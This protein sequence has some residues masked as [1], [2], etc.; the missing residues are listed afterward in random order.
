MSS[1]VG[2]WRAA[3]EAL[4]SERWED[5]RRFALRMGALLAEQPNTILLVERGAAP[6][7][8]RSGQYGQLLQIEPDRRPAGPP[9][10]RIDGERAEP[11]WLD[12]ASYQATTRGG[13]KVDGFLQGKA[14]FKDVGLISG[15]VLLQLADALS[16]QEQLDRDGD[17]HSEAATALYIIG[18]AL[19]VAGALTNPSAD[20]RAWELMPEAWYLVAAR[21]PAGAHSL[22]IEGR[23]YALSVP[24]RGQA[25]A[26]LPSLEPGGPRQ[27]GIE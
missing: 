4:P 18:G 9:A 12:S 3:C 15:Q 11:L 26:L 10:V 21:L 5:E 23:S 27:I 19:F 8:V 16:W 14:I 17:T 24:S 7:K 1:V 6:R 25:V 2:P 20:I 22:E 13:R